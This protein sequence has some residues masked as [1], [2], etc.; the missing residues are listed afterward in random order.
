MDIRVNGTAL[1]LGGDASSLGEALAR[2]DAVIEKAGSV[3]VGLKVDGIDIDADLYSSV[4][5]KATAEVGSVE[6]LAE[7]SRAVRL[8]ALSTLVEL[9]SLAG[10]KAR[11]ER[12]EATGPGEAD[13]PVLRTGAADIREAFSGLFSADELSLVQGFADLL[14]SA[15][16]SPSEGA[17]REISTRCDRL[18][19]VFGER[20]AELQ[21]P[22]REIRTAADLFSA[23]E[24][25]LA[26]LPVLL[27]TGKE[28]RAMRAVLLFIENFNKVL[29]VLPELREAGVDTESLKIGGSGLGEFYSSLNGVLRQLTE[30]FEHKDSVLIGDLAEY[31][32]LPRMKSFFAAMEEALPKP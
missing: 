26:D 6:I 1:D 25:E 27:Q 15:G 31:E 21:N 24:A 12:R 19:A 10:Q 29:R 32:V 2:A 20:L 17:V 28:E 11:E 3:I 5:S 7:S 16:D 30:A 13:W 18:G 14:A 23:Q 4:S 9:I 8:R 22:V